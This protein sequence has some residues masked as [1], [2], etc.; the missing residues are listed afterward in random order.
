LNPFVRGHVGN[1]VGSIR[2]E[3]AVRGRGDN[4]LNKKSMIEE[5]KVSY[6]AMCKKEE[7]MEGKGVTPGVWEIYPGK[8]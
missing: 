5:S 4:G 3:G 2:T 7:L 6:N 1:L 8:S